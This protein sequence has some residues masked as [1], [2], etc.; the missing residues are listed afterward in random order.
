[1]Q[2]LFSTHP[3]N[4]IMHKFPKVLRELREERKLSQTELANKLGYKSATVISNW[5]L[6]IRTPELANLITIADFFRVSIDYL[7]GREQ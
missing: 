2:G 4:L 6:G 7:I 5:E 3:L 1:M